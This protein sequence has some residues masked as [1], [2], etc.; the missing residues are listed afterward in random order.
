MNIRKN[1]YR[2]TPQ[3]LAD[4][5]DALD[6]VKADG[7]YDDF[8]ARHHHAMMDATPMP[9]EEADTNVRN[10]A[11]RGPAFLPWHRYLCREL[12]LLLQSKKKNVT[13]PY[14]DWSADA[15]APLAAPLWNTDPAAGPVY[16]GG[17]GDGPNGEVTTGPFRHWTALIEDLETGGLVPRPGIVRALGTVIGPPDR[18][19]PVFPTAAQVEDMVLNWDTYDEE[20]WARPSRR[21]FR[22]RLEGWRRTDTE[23][24]SQ[25]HNRVHI[26]VGGDMGPGTS[27]NDPVFF[28]HHCNVD[29]LWARWQHSHPN[30]PYLPA[31][32]GPV[33]HNLHDDMAHLVT[34]DATPARSLDY[35]RTLGFVYDTDPPLVEL[36]TPTVNFRNIPSATTRWRPAEF[37]VRAAAPVHLEIVPDSGPVAP[38][39]LT[40]LGGTVTHAPVTDNA[41]FD[42]VR[43]WFAFTGEAA[44]GPAARGPVKIRC[45]ET[46]QVFDVLLTA[47]TVARQTTAVVFALDKSLSM[48][49][50]VGTGD[51]R[52]RLLREAVAQGVELVRD[53][54]GAGVVAFDEDAHSEVKP[55]AFTPDVSQRG[56]VLAA[57]AALE[58]GGDTSVGDGLVAAQ[59][60][61]VPVL[62]DFADHA[63][64]VVTDGLEN[65]PEFLDEVAGT[66]G[67]RTFA[68]G[69]GRAQPV[70]APALTRLTQVTEGSLLIADVLGADADDRFRLS[71][72]VLQ[73][74]ALAADDDVVSTVTGVV[75]P[76]A[77]VRIPFRLTEADI[78]TTVILLSDVASVRLTLE[79]PAGQLLT[80]SDLAALGAPV[81]PGPAMAYCRFRL[82]LDAGPGAHAGTWH[83][84]LTADEDAVREE[85]GRLRTEAKGNP[86]RLVDVDG[87]EAHGPRYG[88]LVHAWSN[89][90][91]HARLT[92]PSLEPGATLRID[93]SLTEFGRRIEGG[94]EVAAEVTRPDGVLVRVPLD[95]ELP[96]AFRGGFEAGMAGVWRIRV[97]ATGHTHGRTPFTREQCFTAAV[98]AGGDGPPVHVVAS[99]ED[100]EPVTG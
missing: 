95:E 3:E 1:I 76:A 73:A 67:L 69:L 38:Y 88:L 91:F 23:A 81:Q 6:A 86:A 72:Y 82:P 92:Q 61:V 12:E 83:V 66:I 24:G 80:E 54:S 19:V 65:Q 52:M 57:V 15:A 29:R 68:V 64:V 25:L 26:W 60:A 100:G 56:D 17:D 47:N 34:T 35:R 74:L 41:P 11:H 30:A 77:E 94:A 33:G 85:T 48:A 58:S 59:Q 39:G 49:R 99:D 36:A 18:N 63:L 20:P 21:S 93:A 53:G 50:P 55:A 87:L 43:F 75:A 96:G 22:N 98:L 32:G 46:G 42:V 37:R 27:P 14:W 5:Q 70:S 62:R 97:T 16:V 89:L 31:S 90:R 78:E 7:S 45:V 8:I 84:R 79:T 2:L 40:T 9:D 13:L 28:L 10:A 4:F 71:S 51:S 44:A